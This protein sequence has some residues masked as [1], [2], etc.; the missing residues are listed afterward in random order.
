MTTMENFGLTCTDAD[1][2]PQASAVAYDKIS[3]ERRK[4]DFEASGSTEVELV[5]VKPGTL[6]QP[7][8]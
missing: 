6:P 7:R 8:T 4:A 3:G 1:G 2:R 5:S